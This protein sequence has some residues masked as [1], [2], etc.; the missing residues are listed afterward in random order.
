MEIQN[1]KVPFGAT[2]LNNTKIQ[3]EIEQLFE[4]DFNTA[5]LINYSSIYTLANLTELYGDSNKD[6]FAYE[7]YLFTKLIEHHQVVILLLKRGAIATSR[8]IVRVM[9]ECQL[10]IIA[11]L[12]NPDFLNKIL[13]YS[14]YE[15]A[16]MI[17]NVFDL[18]KKFNIIKWEELGFKKEDLK[19]S[20]KKERLPVDSILCKAAYPTD[21]LNQ[22]GWYSIYRKFSVD[23]HSNTNSINIYEWNCKSK[24]FE[25][26]LDLLTETI[27]VANQSIVQVK[28]AFERC[29]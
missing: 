15:E 19:Y 17:K 2:N 14:D 3:I 5:E 24:N 11:I 8:S 18:D 1:N 28:E 4:T 20:T 21:E 27:Q 25:V 29:M 13:D 23:I 12:N 7:I 9:I 6:N 22:E 10:K 16:K 26:S